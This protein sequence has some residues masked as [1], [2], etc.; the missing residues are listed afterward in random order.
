MDASSVDSPLRLMDASPA[1]SVASPV[2]TPIAAVDAEITLSRS[3]NDI[4]A[5]ILLNQEGDGLLPIER[6]CFRKGSRK[7]PEVIRIE[8]TTEFPFVNGKFLITREVYHNKM[9]VTISTTISPTE[10]K[11]WAVVSPP[12]EATLRSALG[13]DRI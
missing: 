4:R 2:A 6:S 9:R 1:S 12:D 8:S 10:I 3:R 13:I 5:Q 11:M 7:N